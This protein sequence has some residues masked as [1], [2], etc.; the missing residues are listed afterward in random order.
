METTKSQQ[1]LSVFT[2][3]NNSQPQLSPQLNS[4]EFLSS[5]SCKLRDPLNVIIGFA[6][7]L[8]RSNVG[9]AKSEDFITEIL[10]AANEVNELANDLLDFRQVNLKNFSSNKNREIELEQK[11]I[12]EQ[13]SSYSM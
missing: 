12:K 13:K 5:I 6:E 4:S 2:A 10:N 7:L 3:Q 8:K 1:T 11:L 9:N